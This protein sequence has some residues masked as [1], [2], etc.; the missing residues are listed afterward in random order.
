M[1]I[2]LL[3]NSPILIFRTSSSK[4]S[5]LL[6]LKFVK[7]RDDNYGCLGNREGSEGGCGRLEVSLLEEMVCGLIG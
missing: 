6:S 4:I 3:S 1:C 5:I 2:F 7:N